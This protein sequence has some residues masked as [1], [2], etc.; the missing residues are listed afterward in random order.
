M[1]AIGTAISR[2]R[3]RTPKSTFRPIRP[4]EF[5][6]PLRGGTG[7]SVESPPSVVRRWVRTEVRRLQLYSALNCTQS[8]AVVRYRDG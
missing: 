1:P 4:P 6:D 5:A 3:E 2:P 7:V 8:S